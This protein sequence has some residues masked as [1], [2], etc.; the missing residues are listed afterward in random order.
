[1][2]AASPALFH[3]SG[4][5][6]EIHYLADPGSGL[7]AIVVLHDTSLGPALGGIRCS[8]Y[9][10]EA[11][12]LAEALELAR[13]M[14]F[15]CLLADLPA[16]GGKA[17]VLRHE[18]MDRPAAF[19]AL[20]DFLERLGGRF[21]T[22]GD[23][24]TTEADLRALARRTRYVAMPEHGVAEDLGARAAEGVFV[25]AS[26]ALE[27]LGIDEWRGQRIAI[28][29]LGAVGAKLAMLARRAGARVTAS[30]LDSERAGRAADMLPITLVEP[31][32]IWDT[33]CEVFAPCAGSHQLDETTIPRLRCRIVC[34]SANVPLRTPECAD[35]LAART[36][37]YA[38]DLIVSSGAVIAG[39][40]AAL[41]GFEPPRNLSGIGR[42]LRT[43]VDEA[44]KKKKNPY[45]T[46]ADQAEEKLRD[47]RTRRK[48]QVAVR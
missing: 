39:C 22:A 23:F 10:T 19:E 35:L 25:G 38:P 44:Q 6:E 20:G 18:G 30:D 11:A 48:A 45:R 47:A 14:T 21:F 24:G 7:R 42:R 28:Q 4:D 2:S 46:A 26:T 27:L 8:T 16:G 41:Q 33:E 3:L 13:C 12:A 29:G 17:V 1:V 34:G 32:R 31:D 5:Y 15:K 36:I 37:F 43:L 40:G 9:A